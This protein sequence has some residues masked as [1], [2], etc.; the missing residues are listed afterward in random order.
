MPKTTTKSFIT[1]I[2]LKAGSKELAIL[3][4]RFWA[5]KQQYNALLGEAL[6][7]LR[8]MR[9][10][11]RYGKARELYKQEGKKK[12]AKAI[13]KQLAEEYG[14]SEYALDRK[15]WTGSFLSIGAAITQKIAQRAF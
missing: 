3:K 2:P 6:G 7:R 13:F 12:D 1:E 9:E 15:Q 14:Y 5:A 10:D 8:R 4:K 11:T